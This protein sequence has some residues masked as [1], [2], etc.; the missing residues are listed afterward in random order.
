MGFQPSFGV[1]IGRTKARDL[2]PKLLGV[3]HVSQ[4]REFMQDNVI[5]HRVGRLNEPPI[6]GD[7]VSL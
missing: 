6:Q 4:V 3:V 2:S 5:A 7:T 1:F